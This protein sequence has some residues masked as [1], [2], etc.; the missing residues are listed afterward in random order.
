MLNVLLQVDGDVNL[1]SIIFT[2]KQDSDSDS[3]FDF[4]L[5][6]PVNNTEKTSTVTNTAV[7]EFVFILFSFLKEFFRSWVSSL[8]LEDVTKFK[9]YNLSQYINLKFKLILMCL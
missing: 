9:Q 6:T 3:E 8:S 1:D 4:E 2:E 7:L 5:P